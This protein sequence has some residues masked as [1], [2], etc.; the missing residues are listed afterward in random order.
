MSSLWNLIIK[1]A[2]SPKHC[3][4][5][6]IEY[7]ITTLFTVWYGKNKSDRMTRWGDETNDE[8]EWKI[9]SCYPEI[10]NILFFWVFCSSGEMG[11]LYR[12][13]NYVISSYMKTRSPSSDHNYWKRNWVHDVIIWWT[14]LILNT[15]CWYSHI[16]YSL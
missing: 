16:T 2:T 8:N 7:L 12:N 14:R 5:E 4:F 15:D 13:H 10:D 9:C 11:E 6:Y 3:L 1:R